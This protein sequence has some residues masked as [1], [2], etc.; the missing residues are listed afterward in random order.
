MTD[1]G[2]LAQ[3]VLVSDERRFVINRGSDA[4]VEGGTNYL[5]FRLGDQISDPVTGEDLGVLEIVVGQARTSHVQEKMSTLESTM[6]RVEPGKTRRI[7]RHSVGILR[8][9]GGP[10]QEEVEEGRQVVPLPIDAKV[11][12]YARPV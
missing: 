5:I 1:Y 7:K 9:F 6:T 3:V 8:G 2:E 10:V 4:G 12:D 11:G